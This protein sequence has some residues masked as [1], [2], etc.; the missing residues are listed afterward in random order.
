MRKTFPVLFLLLTLFAEA[1]A[2]QP[3]KKDPPPSASKSSSLFSLALPEVGVGESRNARVQ[4]GVE[5][6]EQGDFLKAQKVFEEILEEDRQLGTRS[7]QAQSLGLLAM[8]CVKLGEL[9]R[10]TELSERQVA[11]LRDLGERELLIAAL[12]NLASLKQARRDL[13]GALQLWCEVLVLQREIRDTA[14][15]AESLYYIGSIHQARRDDAAMEESLGEALGLYRQLRD[16]VGQAKVIELRATAR[17]NASDFPKALE[18]YREVLSRWRAQGDLP[19]VV[20]VLVRLGETQD[21]LGRDLE[22]AATLQEALDLAIQLADAKSES[23]IRS[24]LAG[25]YSRLGQTKKAKEILPPVTTDKVVVNGK[26]I[27]VNIAVD[28]AVSSLT[29]DPNFQ[30]KLYETTLKASRDL[31]YQAGEAIALNGLALAYVHLGQYEKALKLLEEALGLDRKLNNRVG[32]ATVLTNLGSLYSN[33]GRFGKAKEAYGQALELAKALANPS[34]EAGVLT[35]LGK[36]LILQGRYSQALEKF[37]A[38]LEAA[39]RGQDRKQEAILLGNLGSTYNTLGQT[40][41]ALEQQEKAQAIFIDL[42]DILAQANTLN[43]VGLLYFSLGE[44]SRALEQFRLALDLARKTKDRDMEATILFNLGE[45]KMR[46]G[47]SQEA[48][49][50]QGKALGIVR[51]IGNRPH[52]VVLLMGMAEGYLEIGADD[53]AAVI[54]QQALELARTLGHRHVEGIILKHLGG[55]LEE[56]GELEQALSSFE[57]AI[58]IGEEVRRAETLDEFRTGI[59]EH[60]ADAY[61]HAVGILLRLGRPVEAFNLSERARARSF[62]DSLGERQLE[63]KNRE[64]SVLLAEEQVLRREKAAIEQQLIAARSA[65]QGKDDL[66]ASLSGQLA[67]KKTR[68][69]QVLEQIRLQRPEE[70]SLVSVSP[71]S[72]QEVQRR[73]DTTTVLVS[74]YFVPRGSVAFVVAAGSFDAIPLKVTED[75]AEEAVKELQ[76]ALKPGDRA[77]EPLKRLHAWLIEPLRGYLQKPLVGIIPSRSLHLLPFAALTDGKASL[78]ETHPLFYLPCASVLPFIQAKRKPGQHGMLALARGNAPGF[79]SLDYADSEARE[80]AAELGGEVRLGGEATETFLK[81]RAG[82]FGIVHIAAHGELDSGNPLYS[83]L[84]LAPSGDDDG[85]LEVHEVYGLK[86]E[87]TDLVTLSACQTQRGALSQGDDLVSLSRAFLYAGASSLIASL[88]SVNDASTGFLMKE[89][90]RA[91]EQGRTKA[92]ALQLAQARTRERYPEP[93]YWAAFVLTGDSG[94]SAPAELGE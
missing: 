29:A 72:L 11:L 16:A 8:A 28:E 37:L 38:G 21:D 60:S 31:K 49:D 41:K 14:G 1:L 54:Y 44:T 81:T 26:E 48:L 84:V 61:S 66:I 23:E 67:D 88:W 65:L 25:I 9:F 33:L 34:A 53:T 71:L 82:G 86:L 89:L 85:F 57:A 43:S 92:E 76:I 63:G 4:R 46:L 52:E 77:L 64:D 90:Y 91:L 73:L 75:E 80:V 74:F 3:P 7:D 87:K 13:D 6:F 20:R 40:R 36:A 69:A 83:R 68:H 39:R 22:A 70:A 12:G 42:K 78:D 15:I 27:D 55:I 10:A 30:I 79:A 35:G 45:V 32:E 93:Y 18:L 51:E 50:D 17:E 2:S 56:K 59:A 47:R 94:T 19:A 5:Y 62:L 24:S 58:A